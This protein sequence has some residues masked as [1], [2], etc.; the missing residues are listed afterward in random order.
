[1]LAQYV[2]LLA[3]V[4][5]VVSGVY[6]RRFHPL[7]KFPGPFWA[8]QTDVWRVYQLWTRRMPDTLVGVHAKY[9]PVVRIGPNDLSF[10]P[11]EAINP[12]YKSGRKMI[13]SNFYDGFTTFHPNLF[14][15]RDEEV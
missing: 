8:A 14:G 15:T 4:A 11:V 9:G 5:V 3:V 1:M 12:I 13:K 6:N 7:S 2:L 10:Q